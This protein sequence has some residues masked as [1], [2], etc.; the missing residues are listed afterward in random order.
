MT[1]V[2]ERTTR[3]GHVGAVAGLALLA[4]LAAVSWVGDAGLMRLVIE[5]IALLVLAQMWNL[6]AGY[7]GLVS[8]GQQAFFEVAGRSRNDVRSVCS[9]SHS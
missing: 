1:V 9:D 7:A 5:F 8:I 4:A 2:V 3:A 6:L